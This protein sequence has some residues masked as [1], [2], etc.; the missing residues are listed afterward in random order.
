[1]EKNT[2]SRL[3]RIFVFSSSAK[4]EISVLDVDCNSIGVSDE[5]LLHAAMD[6]TISAENSIFADEQFM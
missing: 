1:M 5:E 2:E 6:A 3:F 4:F